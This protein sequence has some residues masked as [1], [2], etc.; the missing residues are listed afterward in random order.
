MEGVALSP[1]FTSQD[2]YKLERCSPESVLSELDGSLE[3]DGLERGPEL[4]F[5]LESHLTPSPRHP[6]GHL[7]D[8]FDKVSL[9]PPL[10]SALGAQC[11][12]SS[13]LPLPGALS[14]AT[15]EHQQTFAE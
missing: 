3:L 8:S 12:D 1:P 4:Q 13:W 11:E 10:S 5:L 15:A 7:M 9:L 2:Q 14:G 6:D